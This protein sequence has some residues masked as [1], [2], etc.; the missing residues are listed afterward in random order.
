MFSNHTVVICM[1]SSN[2]KGKCTASM[3]V[4]I[5]VIF[6]DLQYQM[7]TLSERPEDTLTMISEIQK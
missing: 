5:Y 7:Y 4:C 1:K 3:S 6:Q 2:R